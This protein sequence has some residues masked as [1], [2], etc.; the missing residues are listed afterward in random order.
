MS[1]VHI[2][3]GAS[4]YG[5][6]DIE[7][8]GR[9]LYVVD[10]DKLSS[11]L[12]AAG[13]IEQY[14]QYVI[15]WTEK[16]IV[17]EDYEHK[18]EFRKDRRIKE[19]ILRTFLEEHQRQL[20]KGEKTLEQLIKSISRLEFTSCSDS[21]FIRNG[22]GE[23]YIP[24]SSVKGVIRTA[25]MW[26]I[27]KGNSDWLNKY[28]ARRI[29]S[30]GKKESLAEELKGWVFEDYDIADGSPSSNKVDQGS[31]TDFMKAISITDSTSISKDAII[32]ADIKV[33]TL[34]RDRQPIVKTR[35]RGKEFAIGKEVFSG[36]RTPLNLD[37]TL[38]KGVLS[39]FRN[40]SKENGFLIPFATVKDILNHVG[41]FSR[42]LWFE[43]QKFFCGYTDKQGRHQPVVDDKAE[44][45]SSVVD[46]Y[47]TD[48][49][50]DAYYLRI[51]YGSGL[52]GTTVF[53]LLNDPLR[54]D[55]RNIILKKD[56]PSPAPKS[57]RLAFF[58]DG[59]IRP[60]GWMCLDASSSVNEFGEPWQ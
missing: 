60:L 49:R 44:F 47:G 43:E 4:N 11:R 19:N 40:R 3:A 18:S 30:H 46:F 1:P 24:A 13:L 25:L 23:P 20:E 29:S 51:G 27:L 50:K 5:T 39:S 10:E 6:T 32:S 58:S 15:E 57:R 34:D 22:N 17:K 54:K 26:A 8:N 36:N 53:T 7:M 55:I 37:I 33:I 48:I 41:A 45:L 31:L 16:K 35:R 59:A 14:V 56:Y 9:R 52:L 28:V 38:D 42:Q 12:E 21:Q 2:S